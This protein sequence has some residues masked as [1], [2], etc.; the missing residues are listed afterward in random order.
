MLLSSRALQFTV[1]KVE[2]SNFF[3]SR[4]AVRY[5]KIYFSLHVVVK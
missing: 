4:I 1:F 5:T 3:V 2:E